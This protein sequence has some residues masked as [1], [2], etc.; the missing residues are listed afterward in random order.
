[1]RK[2]EWDRMFYGFTSG[3]HFC[4]RQRRPVKP[5]SKNCTTL[6]RARVLSHEWNIFPLTYL[7]W[8]ALPQNYILRQV[9]LTYNMN[10]EH[11]PRDRTS[12]LLLLLVMMMM[13][14]RPTSDFFQLL[15][16]WFSRFFFH[17]LT[18]SLSLFYFVSFPDQFLILLPV[19]CLLKTLRWEGCSEEGREP[20]ASRACVS[21]TN[22]PAPFYRRAHIGAGGGKNILREEGFFSQISQRSIPNGIPTPCISALFRVLSNTCCALSS[23][24]HRWLKGCLKF[25]Q[26][27]GSDYIH[28][29]GLI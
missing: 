21:Q 20:L 16:A 28:K 13:I 4:S 25:S 3:L 7:R 22:L 23:G 10:R 14:F 11:L 5:S 9:P 17:S 2:F 24:L 12:F 6:A 29:V 19:K 15:R 26:W 8:C 27:T 18:V 1:M